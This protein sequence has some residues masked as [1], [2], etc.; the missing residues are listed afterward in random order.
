MPRYSRLLEVEKVLIDEET[1]PP[2]LPMLQGLGGAA[3]GKV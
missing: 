2:G 3:P 1:L